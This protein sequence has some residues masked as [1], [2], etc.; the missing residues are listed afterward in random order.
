MKFLK[1]MALSVLAVFFGW[2]IIAVNLSAHYAG[3]KS[4]SAADVALAWVPDNPDALLN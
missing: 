2:R 3:Q 4:I 1:W